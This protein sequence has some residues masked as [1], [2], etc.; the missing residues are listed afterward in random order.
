MTNERTVN[1]S[2]GQRFLRL[3]ANLV[4]GLALVALLLIALY[5]GLGRQVMGNLHHYTGELEEMIAGQIGR[6]VSIG[7]LE[8][9]WRGLDPVVKVT[10][11]DILGPDGESVAVSLGDLRLRLDSRVS[12]MRLRLVLSEFSVSDA[13]LRVVQHQEGMFSVDGLWQPREDPLPLPELIGTIVEER[14]QG[15]FDEL[16]RL[17]HEPSLQVNNLSLTLAVAGEPEEHFVLPH[18]DLTFRRGLFRA[19]GQLNSPQSGQQV[20]L[21]SLSGQHFFSGDFTGQLYVQFSSERLFDS[22]LR[23]YHWQRLAIEGVDLDARAWMTFD[24]GRPVEGVAKLDIP[25]LSVSTP[26]GELTPVEALTTTLGWKSREQGWQLNLEQLR[27]RWQGEDMLPVSA[28]VQRDEAG[29]EV[30]VDQLDAGPMTRLLAAT[31]L[32]PERANMEMMER[33]PR[34]RLRHL[35]LTRPDEGPWQFAAELNGLEVAAFRGTPGGEQISGLLRLGARNGEILLRPGPLRV[36][37]PKLFAGPWGFEHVSGRVRWRRHGDQWRVEGEE[38]YARHPSQ[39]RFSGGFLLR[40]DPHDENVLS[41]RVG[42]AEAHSDLLPA[43]VPVHKVPEGLYGFLSRKISD[44]RIPWGWYY[45][46]GTVQK[47]LE[48]PAFTSSMEYHFEQG[49][50]D[51]LETMPPLKQARGRVQVHDKEARVVLEEGTV[52]GT[53]LQPS[54]VQV[55]PS[56]QGPKVTIRTGTR[57]KGNLLSEQWLTQSPLTAMTGQ[58]LTEVDITGELDL[59]LGIRVFPGQERTPELSFQADVQ[60]AR[61]QH[62]PSGLQWQALNGR[63]DYHPHQ[64]FQDSRLAGRFM[65]TPVTLDFTP[66]SGALARI[67]QRGALSVE[68][69]EGWLEKPLPGLAGELVYKAGVN[70]SKSP[71]LDLEADLEP[72]ASRWPAPLNKPLG[73]PEKLFLSGE[74]Q[75]QGEWLFRGNWQERLATRLRWKDGAMERASL[76]LGKDASE[77]PDT[78]GLHVEGRLPRLDL[79]QWREAAGW[80]MAEANDEPSEPLPRAWHP[81]ALPQWFRSLDLGARELVV[82]NRA[83]GPTALTA[84]RNEQGVWRARVS[85]ESA[86]GELVLHPDAPFHLGLEHLHLPSP[87]IPMTP[88]AT[89][90]AATLPVPVREEPLEPAPPK[91]LEAGGLGRLSAA[92]RALIPALDVRIQKLVLGETAL[93]QWNF[94]LRQTT[95]AVSLQAMNVSFDDLVFEGGLDWSFSGTV[96]RTF[97]KGHLR[98]GDIAALERF[99][100]QGVPLRSDA[101]GVALDLSWLGAPDAMTLS[102]LQGTLAFWLEDGRIL[103]DSDTA[104]IFGIFGL[105]NTDTLWRRLRLDFSDVADGG[106]AFDSLEG[107]ALVTNGR[108]ILDPDLVI[109]APSGGFL[110]S[111]ETNLLDE[112]L[113]MR[114]V[115]V[116][117]VTQNL[118]LAAVLVGAAPVAA[119]LYVVDRM[120]GGRLSRITSATYSLRGTWQDPK[121]RLRN[122]FDTESELRSY[123]R[124]DLDQGSVISEE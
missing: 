92:Q 34:G 96:P 8:G 100:P 60:D 15:W 50:L 107:R 74:H 105:L 83:L 58:W 37:F 75:G 108:L 62:G 36:D 46:H 68:T 79:D 2:P 87:R 56:E 49:E 35:R 6:P 32:L 40:V 82:A 24:Q 42:V 26:D 38:L 80:V 122:L 11:L 106:I 14:L 23:R 95:E 4:W 16:G 121:A 21:F 53:P 93:G 64:G 91:R 77:R 22:L 1:M 5:V 9:D 85:G 39:A 17:L 123:K 99:L 45:G 73:K 27:Y 7:R 31:G 103:E 20:A 70:V 47:D 97:L 52:A 98:G 10:G 66:V 51:Y 43:F 111:G 124:P 48:N 65:D 117:P 104:R 55:V 54:R 94:D 28:R 63:L 41:V 84:S 76:T 59:D 12:L 110:M 69:L 101:M 72:L 29:L 89:G 78:P 119:L 71:V 30:A 109:Q 19:S 114:L 113:D 116:L 44:T 61:V 33:S 115:V 120:F 57:L 90:T 13:G 3:L 88:P 102:Q 25:F 81:S 112:T 118:P 67:Q 86:R 18:A